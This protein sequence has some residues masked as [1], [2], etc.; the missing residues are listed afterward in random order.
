LIFSENLSILLEN[1][2]L[3]FKFIYLKKLKKYEIP[4]VHMVEDV[5]VNSFFILI[6]QRDKVCL[7]TS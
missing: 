4:C 2:F 1:K 7:K 5:F 6:L 3:K